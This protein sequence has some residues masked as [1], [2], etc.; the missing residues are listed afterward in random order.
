MLPQ[1]ERAILADINTLRKY[2]LTTTTLVS[3]AVTL[4]A[5]ACGDGDSSGAA[6]AS[7]PPISTT[8]TSEVTST[9][10]DPRIRLYELKPGENLSMVADA[11]D[12]SL[13]SLINFND[14]KFDDP[15]NVP[16]GVVLEIPP[17]LI[18]AEL[19]GSGSSTTST[20]P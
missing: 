8:T 3:V 13:E 9:T 5:A 19:P 1:R 12:V 15:N 10:I 14:A 7:L 4:G 16:P 20:A 11:F 6:T 2:R 17:E 18:V